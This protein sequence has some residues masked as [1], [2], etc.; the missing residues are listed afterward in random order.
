MRAA[1]YES[2]GDP[3]EVLSVGE[4]PKPEPK[5][6]QARV[7]MVR[8]A[9]HN[10]D[11]WM[12]RGSYGVR[13]PLPA[14]GGSEAS[15]VVDALGEGTTGLEIGQ[16]VT[17]FA[18]GAWAEYFVS[19][20]AG[21][22]PLPD[23]IP[24]DI[25]CQL[26]AMPLSAMTLV[27][28]YTVKPGEWIAQNA[29]NGAVGK[30]LATIAKSRSINVLNLV[31]SEAAAKELADAGIEGA[32]STGDVDWKDRVTELVGEARVVYG[33]DSV[34]GKGTSDLA[35]VLSPGGTVVAFGSM[36][37]EPMQITAGELIFR[38]LKMEGF[39][40]STHNQTPTDR[41]RRIRDLVTLIAKG[42]LQLPVAG[43][44][45]LDEAAT[46]ANASVSA[47]RRGKVLLKP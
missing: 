27:D 10:H 46:A 9:I 24:D 22:L 23:A 32:I 2:F 34:G 19:P 43:V 36:T 31:R 20:A 1:V 7:R 4:R 25:A 39:W 3:G 12:I 11:L 33:I 18:N 26:V 29:A 6:G 30:T 28:H 13:P 8:A 35:S 14:I 37:G 21:L 5:P 15:G 17:G 44:Y 47:G 38:A 45:S 41:T 16:R 40:L 42:D